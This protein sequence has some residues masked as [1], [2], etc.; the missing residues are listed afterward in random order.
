MSPTATTSNASTKSKNFES[1][2]KTKA[3]T[4]KPKPTTLRRS[5][6]RK[7][8][9][10]NFKAKAATQTASVAENAN[11]KAGTTR[12]RLYEFVTE[13][14][15]DLD[16]LGKQE[17]IVAAALQKTAPASIATIAAAC[18]GLETQQ[19]PSAVV[20]H[21]IGRWKKDGFVRIVNKFA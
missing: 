13:K 9:D 14:K 16:T 2:K 20:A 5:S 15:L 1:K 17:K 7:P 8:T 18:V 6:N 10:Q 19:K 12:G 21:Y 3:R 11:G 4:V